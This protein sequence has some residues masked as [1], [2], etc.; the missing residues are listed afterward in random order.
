MSYKFAS[1]KHS[2]V[3]ILVCNE[4]EVSLSVFNLLVFESVEFFWQWSNGFRE[5]CEF[6]HEKGKLTFVCM[7][8]FSFYSDKIP[9]IDEFLS[10][11]ISTHFLA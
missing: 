1:E 7:K 10:K 11:F 5:E 3:G 8:Q 6:A 4:V 9:K 2:V